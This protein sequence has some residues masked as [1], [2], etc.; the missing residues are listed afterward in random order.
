M[1]AAAPEGTLPRRIRTIQKIGL[2]R[3]ITLDK[4]HCPAVPRRGPET[5]D[6]VHATFMLLV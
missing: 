2:L 4:T 1:N 6:L 3:K 5:G